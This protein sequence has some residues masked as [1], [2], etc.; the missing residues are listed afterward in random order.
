MTTSHVQE[1]SAKLQRLEKYLQQDPQNFALLT[2][3]LDTALSAG[4]LPSAQQYLGRALELEPQNVFLLHSQATLWISLRRYPEAQALLQQLIEAGATAPTV[5][6]NLGY[7]MYRQGRFNEAEQVFASIG[8]DADAPPETASMRLR[9]L[10]HAGDLDQ[11]LAY[12][13]QLDE[14]ALLT[15]STSGVASLVC[16]DEGR[17]EQA[18]RLATA[19]LMKNPNQLEALI[20]QASLAL[21]NR[22]ATTAAQ[23]FSRVLEI[24][25]NEGRAHSGLGFAGLLSLNLSQAEAA[26]TTAKTYMPMDIGVWQGA[27]WCYFM[28]GQ[29]DKAR[30]DFEAALALAPDYA[31]IYGSLAM[32]DVVEKRPEAAQDRIRTARH[33]DPDCVTA[34]YAED[35]LNGK[36]EIPEQTKTFVQDLLFRKATRH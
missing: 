2:D 12:L 11:A 17:E 25:P 27:G 30:S 28:L 34:Q 36:T 31:E 33:Y 32:L 10:H 23:V 6:F 21:G 26:F 5:R 14:T 22:D 4:N 18:E 9:C 29:L 1:A 7:A 20:T 16:L 24:S 35:W 15:G 19:A 3:A 13:D 8:S